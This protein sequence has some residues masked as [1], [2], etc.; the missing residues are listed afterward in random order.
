MAVLAIILYFFEQ[1]KRFM[2]PTMMVMTPVPK[3]NCN[4]PNIFM[5]AA[6]VLNVQKIPVNWKHHDEWFLHKLKAVT[7]VLP[8]LIGGFVQ[9]L[10]LSVCHSSIE[11]A[12]AM[13]AG[14]PVTLLIIWE[15]E[16]LISV[17]VPHIQSKNRTDKPVAGISYWYSD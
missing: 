5:T 9:F 1:G 3:A 14:F 6:W 16:R 11:L 8:Q 4:L 15:Y 10:D 2:Q 7:H 12:V 17:V 13:F